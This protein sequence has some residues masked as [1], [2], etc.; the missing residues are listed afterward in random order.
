MTDIVQ[1]VVK[2]HTLLAETRHAIAAIHKTP[3]VLHSIDPNQKPFRMASVP[4]TEFP[5]LFIRLV[6]HHI[7][8][9]EFMLLAISLAI[10][11]GIHCFYSVYRIQD[12]QICLS[13]KP[14]RPTPHNKNK[15][16]LPAEKKEN[17]IA[18]NPISTAQR[19]ENDIDS[20]VRRVWVDMWGKLGDKPSYEFPQ[21]IFGPSFRPLHMSKKRL[22]KMP[23][24]K[25]ERIKWYLD[26]LPEPL[27]PK[28][29]AAAQ[30]KRNEALLKDKGVQTSPIYYKYFYANA[31]S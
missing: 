25:F 3:N 27:T 2:A 1:Q 29:Y 31:S 28:D 12:N 11:S 23:K 19:S 16:T 14:I 5:V 10:C 21:S 22:S 26:C 6:W 8:P 17:K 24:Q 20:S 9:S 15:L 30:T 4:W 18:H 7:Q 13:N